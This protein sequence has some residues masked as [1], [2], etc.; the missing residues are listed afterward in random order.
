MKKIVAILLLGATLLLAEGIHWEKDYRAAVK[1]AQAVGK[2][3]L[4]VF[5]SHECKWCRHLEA[6]TF[7][8]P[9]VIAELNRDFVNVIAYTDAGDYVPREL[10]VPGT[11]ALWFLD[12]RGEAM[13]QPI[14]GAVGAQ[15]FLSAT[16]I[17]LKAYAKER[18]KQRYGN[19]KK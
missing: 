15:D 17:V 16:D 19:Q 12:P 13:F 18:L 4:F 6:T 1:K 3:I 9:K 2:P 11:P 5:S 14:Q 10:W 8:D 7:S